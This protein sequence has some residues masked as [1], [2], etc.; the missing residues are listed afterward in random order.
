MVKKVVLGMLVTVATLCAQPGPG[1]TY[2]EYFVKGMR[3]G[4]HLDYG[5]H[6]MRIPARICLDGAIGA[7]VQVEQLLCHDGTRGLAISL[8]GNGW[9]RFPE[10]DSI[11]R[12]V[13]QYQYKTFPTASLPLDFFTQGTGNKFKLMVDETQGWWPQ[14]ILT[15]LTFRIYYRDSAPTIVRARARIVSPRSGQSIGENPTLKVELTPPG[16]FRIKQVDYIGCYTDV[17][18]DGDGV[19]HEWHAHPLNGALTHHLGTVTQAPWELQWNTEWVPDQRR[20]LKFMARVALAGWSADT[21][22]AFYMTEAVDNVTFKRSSGSVTL[23][24]SD[25]V[26]ARWVTRNGEQAQW[27]DAPKLGKVEAAQLVWSSWSPCYSQGVLLNG[28]TVWSVDTLLHPCYE[29]AFL[30]VNLADPTLVRSG[31][32]TVSTAQPVGKT[33]HGMEVNWPGFQLLVRTR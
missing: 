7:E 9:I 25:S 27:L 21:A 4:G 6:E 19:H 5:G 17:D 31:R 11:A 2:C 1:T 29:D 13:H 26:P 28:K 12:P 20:P 18:Y 30:R 23:V 24:A 33:N 10:G 15:G 32:N 22:T 16:R 3:V 8:N 14:N